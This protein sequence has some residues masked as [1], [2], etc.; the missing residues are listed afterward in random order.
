[1]LDGDLLDRDVEVLVDEHRPG[2]RVPLAVRRRA[3][4][5]GDRAVRVHLDRGA[6]LEF[7][8][9]QLCRLAQDRIRHTNLADVVQ[10]RAKLQRLHLFTTQ[11]VLTSQSQ[12]V[13]DN[14][15]RMA[16]RFLVACFECGGQRFQRRAISVFQRVER[17]VEFGGSLFD[18]LFEMVLV[19]L[20]GNNQ[21]VMFK[22]AFDD[23]FDLPQIEGLHQIIERAETQSTDRALDSLHAA[24][25]YYDCVGRMFFDVRD[26]VQPA[27]AGH[28]DVADH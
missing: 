2:G 12:T 15:F 20:L 25:H 14:S 16:V 18:Q 10:Q 21:V 8:F 24:D 1:M 4:E 7:F 23:R 17:A 28:R 6:L 9:G 27:H 5:H 19:T 22:R 11:S 26:H 3:G 13:T